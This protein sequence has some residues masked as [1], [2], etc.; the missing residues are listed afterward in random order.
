MLYI[1]A[2]PEEVRTA[3]YWTRALESGKQVICP[4]VDARHRRL[5][6]YRVE[7]RNELR[8]GVLG[9]PEPR[10]DLPEVAP[11]SIDWVLVPGLAFSDQGYRLGRGAGHYDR[12]MPQLRSDAVCWA[13]LP[14]VSADSA[15]LPVEPHD[16]PLDG[17]CTPERIIHGVRGKSD[18]SPAEKGVMGAR[19]GSARGWRASPRPNHG[20]TPVV[21]LKPSRDCRSASIGPNL[22][23][24]GPGIRLEQAGQT[25][26][27]R[28]SLV[29]DHAVSESHRLAG[30]HGMTRLFVDSFVEIVH[31]EWIGG[32]QSVVPDVPGRGKPEALGDG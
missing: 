21:R 11:E 4:R 8:P 1:A 7:D 23:D 22:D 3:D 25:V 13:V 30:R 14:V 10:E 9:I 18:A 2:F 6:L 20:L 32:E 28:V 12:L 26:A 15:R 27:C 31:A 29:Q 19:V 16:M 5:R 17:V 24:R